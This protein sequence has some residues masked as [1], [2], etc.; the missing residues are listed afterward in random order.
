MG[1]YI[2]EGTVVVFVDN[3]RETDFVFLAPLWIQNSRLLGF[4][5]RIKQLVLFNM[6]NINNLLPAAP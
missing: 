4:F 6:I 2:E 3:A 5:R 1:L